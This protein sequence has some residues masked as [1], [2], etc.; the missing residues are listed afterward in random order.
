MKT[1][2]G[3][4]K[5]SKVDLKFKKIKQLTKWLLNPSSIKPIFD[6]KEFQAS[7]VYRLYNVILNH[8]QLIVYVNKYLNNLY[9]FH[10]YN[11][12]DYLFTFAKLLH[13][14]NIRSLN[15]LYFSKYQNLPRNTFTDT[16]NKFYKTVQEQPLNQDEIN[17]LFEL[18]NVGI[19]S[20]EI[21][22]NIKLTIG[23]KEKLKSGK[24]KKSIVIP[25]QQINVKEKVTEINDMFKQYIKTRGACKSCTL[26]NKGTIVLDTNASCVDNPSNV[27]IAVVGLSPSL[28]D[29]NNNL[30][31]S[32][33]FGKLFR[34]HFESMTKKYGL[35][36]VY[37]N[38]LMCYSHEGD[39]LKGIRNVI[40]GCKSVTDLVHQQFPSK[41]Q[42]YLGQKVCQSNGIK[43]LLSKNNGQLFGTKFAMMAPDDITDRNM[44]KF[45][46][47]ITELDSILVKMKKESIPE[48]DMN[49]VGDQK[50]EKI[51]SDFTLFN[52]QV[53]GETVLYVFIDKHGHKKYKTEPIKYPVYFSNGKYKDCEYI[54][55]KIDAVTYLTAKQ[56]K[57]LMYQLNISLKNMLE[58]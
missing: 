15:Q 55:D 56:K 14:F 11:Q 5:I 17:H 9:D 54:T 3:I 57:N 43:G 35:T 44:P 31:F 47:A 25:E 8:P 48:A 42:I 34:Y 24:A 53:L 33:N 2:T 52:I 58:R 20:E 50:V 38:S 45:E 28:E 39:K 26:N 40:S 37:T 1:T 23:G 27:D 10:K 49:L 51:S 4:K 6:E 18:Y 46:K 29:V 13:T 36:Y 19:I 16:I 41:L 12:Q 32:D 30:P 22:D 21:I 7:Y